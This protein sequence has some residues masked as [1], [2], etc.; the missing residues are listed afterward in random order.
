MAL[1]RQELVYTEY[2][3][4]MSRQHKNDIPILDQ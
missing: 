2:N 1:L 3:Y 4:R